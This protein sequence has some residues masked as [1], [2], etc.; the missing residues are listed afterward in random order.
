VIDGHGAGG[1]DGNGQV[2]CTSTGQHLSLTPSE[3]ALV[4]PFSNY[5]SSTGW[6]WPTDFP[7]FVEGQQCGHSRIQDSESS[8]LGTYCC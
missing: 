8:I 6:R 1:I 5:A 3:I 2:S 7:H 4:E